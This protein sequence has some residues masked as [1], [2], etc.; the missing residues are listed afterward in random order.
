MRRAILRRVFGAQIGHPVA[1]Y[2][3]IEIRKPS[4]LTIGSGSAIG[5]RVTLDAR[6]TLVIGSHVNISSE[7]MIWT[8]QHDYRDPEFDAVYKPVEIGDYA[9]LGPRCIILP[10]VKIGRGAVVAAGAVV[11]KDVPP[12]AVVAGVPARVVAQRPDAFRYRPSDG[13]KPFAN[14]A[15]ESLD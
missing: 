5:H 2:S 4:G 14:R 7:A 13:A 15:A 10:G 3:G 8:A 9:W 12:C 6:G 11:P 1:L